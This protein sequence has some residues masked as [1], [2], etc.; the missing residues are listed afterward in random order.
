MTIKLS[1][2]S[3]GL[4]RVV[5]EQYLRDNESVQHR[6]C[7]TITG[8]LSS[9]KG[10]SLEGTGS[11]YKSVFNGQVVD[12]V[13]Q[14]SDE[15][16]SSVPYRDF[17]YYTD[18]AK[19]YKYNKDNLNE[20]LSVGLDGRS[21]FI[22]GVSQVASGAAN[23]L[24]NFFNPGDVFINDGPIDG[25]ENITEVPF[26]NFVEYAWVYHNS[27]T[28]QNSVI[29]NSSGQITVNNAPFNVG[30]EPPAEAFVKL[31][32]T[33]IISSPGDT[34]LLFR[35][36]NG[37]ANGPGGFDYT[38]FHLVEIFYKANLG[39]GDQWVSINGGLGYS[40][41][42]FFV[43]AFKERLIVG[44]ADVKIPANENTPGFSYRFQT[45][46]YTDPN[47]EFHPAG[48]YQYLV[49]IFDVS[50]NNESGPSDITERITVGENTI[51]GVTINGAVSSIG[52][53]TA[54]DKLR[55]KVYRSSQT[56]P[57]FFL[58]G[59]TPLNEDGSFSLTTNIP[60]DEV[61][62]ENNSEN[63]GKPP[64]NGKYLTEIFGTFLMAVDSFIYSSEPGNPEAWSPLNAISVG[65]TITG[66]ANAKDH[67][68]VFT[69]SQTYRLT[70]NN[71]LNFTLS[72]LNLT[73]GCIS[74][75][76]LQR[77]DFGLFWL[78]ESAVIRYTG[79]QLIP[80]HRD[81]LGE[82]TYEFDDVKGSLISSERYFVF[83]G[84]ET[85]V[86]DWRDGVV[87]F[88][89]RS[90]QAISGYSYK[91]EIYVVKDEDPDYG[92]DGFAAVSY[93]AS[94]QIVGGS[95]VGA[96]VDSFSASGNVWGP[97]FGHGPSEF[98]GVELEAEVFV[99]EVSWVNISIDSDRIIDGFVFEGSNDGVSYTPIIS[100]NAGVYG[101][102]SFTAPVSHTEKYRF[103][104]IRSTSFIESS[105]AGKSFRMNEI[106]LSGDQV[107]YY[108][109]ETGDWLPM[110]YKSGAF[111]EQDLTK[112]K[113]HNLIYIYYTG[114]IY[115]DLYI[116]DFSTPVK[117]ISPPQVSTFE[118]HIED[119]RDLYGR[120][121]QFGIRTDGGISGELHFIENVTDTFEKGVNGLFASRGDRVIVS[122]S[123]GLLSYD[124][125]L[126]EN[127][128]DDG[129]ADTFH[130]VVV[131]HVTNSDFA[132]TDNLLNIFVDES[133]VEFP[134]S[135]NTSTIEVVDLGGGTGTTI[136]LKGLAAHE[137]RREI[138]SVPTGIHGKRVRAVLTTKDG[139]LES[140]N[141]LSVKPLIAGGSFLQPDISAVI[142]RVDDAGKI[143]GTVNLTGRGA[144][145]TTDKIFDRFF[146][147]FKGSIE[148]TVF[149]DGNSVISES[150]SFQDTERELDISF[151]KGIVGRELV[152]AYTLQGFL[153]DM[154]YSDRSLAAH[155]KGL[156]L[157]EDRRLE[158]SG[159]GSQV[160]VLA[161]LTKAGPDRFLDKEFQYLRVLHVGTTNYTVTV[162][163]VAVLTGNLV[164]AG[165]AFV[166]EEIP[167]PDNTIGRNISL[168]YTTTGEVKEMDYEAGVYT[169][170]NLGLSRPNSY[171]VRIVKSGSV[172]TFVVDLTP[173]S[174]DATFEKQLDILF[175]TFKGDLTIRF[176]ADDVEV[177]SESYSEAGITSKQVN[178]I[179]GAR[180]KI[181]RLEYEIENGVLWNADVITDQR[182][183]EGE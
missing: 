144:D 167:F 2:F 67:V 88:K 31:P 25:T 1:D 96:P 146:V 28:S 128:F 105:P 118:V 30:N 46:R 153:N 119:I 108:S 150:H 107:P 176:Y 22:K 50:T 74:Y 15:A 152:V 115:V 151:D 52:D 113:Q 45:Y 51:T 160:T 49:T 29:G 5:R 99:N 64:E 61:I 90:L 95:N 177:L 106:R 154:R 44:N 136:K 162:D 158:Y 39:S 8:V 91:G 183:R 84:V 182:G 104:R 65:Q 126:Y 149:V 62:F 163:G 147:S 70:G 169:R 120:F 9:I 18:N 122:K 71:P 137:T 37:T 124:A 157:E 110:Q 83:L 32:N 86:V 92:F 159:N 42:G 68:L 138:I 103:Y 172:T 24:Q 58:V 73:H 155:D 127:Q 79:Q 143:V 134:I 21:I 6:D 55:I 111:A 72:S 156:A 63:Q 10:E 181:L 27:A 66:M 98:I 102:V 121:V 142:E 53:L 77:S 141:H 174:D 26:T 12:L 81:A 125:L 59:D 97:S 3:G 93:F 13:G 38:N 54:R 173:S 165:P 100:D 7:E 20:R 87:K 130:Q 170:S 34:I 112:I 135:I 140:L 109:L 36:S 168:E 19:L 76:S 117:T 129:V 80:I 75:N 171:P 56:K 133:L 114:K 41:E 47:T 82:V 35:K 78:S 11:R 43:D 139:R 180:G 16:Y 145:I 179:A 175:F 131:T 166:E 69:E 178:F 164:N 89:E 33:S 17:L 60:D 132:T 123:G 94:S 48:E 85:L 23:P 116:D 161:K 40:S 57:S 148:F 4:R 101:L 14:D